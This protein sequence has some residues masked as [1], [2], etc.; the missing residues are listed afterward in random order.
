[1]IFVIFFFKFGDFWFLPIS[2][3]CAQN[4]GQECNEFWVMMYLSRLPQ[5]IL[6][7]FASVNIM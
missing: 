2:N 4:F 3:I 6:R 5:N 1:M 7:F